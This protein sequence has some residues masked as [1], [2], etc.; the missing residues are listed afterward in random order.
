[1]ARARRN[2]LETR[3]AATETLISESRLTPAEVDLARAR[4]RWQ[5]EFAEQHFL[6]APE[7]YFVLPA[8]GDDEQALEER[9]DEAEGWFERLRLPYRR[10][11]LFEQAAVLAE[12]YN[13][14]AP[15]KETV[16]G[17]ITD[18]L[19]LR[20]LVDDGPPQYRAIVRQVGLPPTPALP[21]EPLPALA[22]VPDPEGV[23][24]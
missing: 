8:Q 22:V 12:A 5:R 6:A 1:V 17:F 13:V 18:R 3:L 14:P 10:L 2:R 15:E 7:I 9:I 20:V 19:D 11:D 16:A 24:R 21:R 23:S 4:V